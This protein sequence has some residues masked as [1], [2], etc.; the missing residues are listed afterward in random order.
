MIMNT[1][2][3][4]TEVR[5]H[6]GQ[7]N[8]DVVRKGP[9]FVQR[10]RDEWAAMSKE[11]LKAAFQKCEFKAINFEEDD[12]SITAVI[13]DFGIVANGEDI[14]EAVEE[15]A[16]YLIEYAEEYFENFDQ[17]FR[18]PNR[19]EHFPFVMNVL[20]QDNIQGVKDLITCP[21]GKK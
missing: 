19:R 15:L 9:Q 5:K 7:F 14:N 1:V 8:D 4:S 20:V 10:N 21:V 2:L 11:Q 17:Y 3:K 16:E 12:G 13:E 6:W 18:A